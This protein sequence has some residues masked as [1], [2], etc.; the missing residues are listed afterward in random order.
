MTDKEFL[1][2]TIEDETPRFER[3]LKAFP[4]ELKD[5]RAHPKNRSA[6]EIASVMVFDSM[7]MPIILE[8]GEV[9]FGKEGEGPPMSMSESARMIKENFKKTEKLVSKMSDKDWDGPAKM[10]MNGKVMWK[11]TKGGAVWG[12][13]LDMIHHRGQLSTHIR[14]QG[15]MVPSIYGPSADDSGG[16]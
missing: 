10:M 2:N 15:G 7:T 6:Q 12:T 11:T 13:V 4:D 9:D 5:W 3:T 1:K 14:P 8:K 16:M